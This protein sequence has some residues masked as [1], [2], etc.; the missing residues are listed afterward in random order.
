MPREES[1]AIPLK[2]LDVT[3]NTDTSLD[4]LWEKLIE[5]YSNVAGDREL[6]DAWTGLARFTL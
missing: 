2:M 5:D 4:V 6:S 3:T 1:F